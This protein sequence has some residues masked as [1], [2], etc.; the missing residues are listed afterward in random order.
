MIPVFCH[1]LL[2]LTDLFLLRFIR[3]ST[4]TPPLHFFLLAEQGVLAVLFAAA[5]CGKLLYGYVDFHLAAHALAWHGSFFLFAS[6]WLMNRQKVNG[7]QRR[8]FPLLIAVSGC[9]Y[10]TAA[11]DALLFEPTALTVRETEI[12]SPKITKP[13][14]VVFCTDIQT[15]RIGRYE[16]FTLQK[17]KEQNADLILFG[18]DYIQGKTEKDEQRLVKELNTLLKKIDW[19][20]PLGIF[21]V[22]GNQEWFLNWK[23]IFAGT[24][25]AAE[26]K[27]VSK[28]AGELRLTLLS[29]HSS[30]QKVPVPDKE[31][32]GK[33]RIITGHIPVFAMAGQDADL[34]LA[35][36][37]HGGQVQIPFFGPLLTNAGD[38]PRKWASGMTRLP[39]GGTLIVSNG[40]G[41]ERGKAP[42]V[43]FWCRPDIWVIRLK[44]SGNEMV[45]EIVR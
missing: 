4:F 33:F 3:R 35:G 31:R 12:L 20:P 36:H 22:Q 18:G 40:S 11:A 43:R 30:A 29:L 45:Q 32:N 8:T 27:T 41:L 2:F 23:E 7:K 38:L 5:V 6:A 14:T 39:G 10:C 37:T 34:L 21:A 24:S 1:A 13:L 28:D 15:D 16:H 44:P 42:R 19:K 25:V 17:I 26:E 9:I